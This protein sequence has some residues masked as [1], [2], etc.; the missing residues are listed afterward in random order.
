MA[1]KIYTVFQNLEKTLNGGWQTTSDNRSVSSYDLTNSDTV[2]YKTDN[3]EDY[4]KK[5]LE[6]RQQTYLNNMW[7]TTNR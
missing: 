1:N 5:K 2:L 6:L 3:K 4:E 7:K